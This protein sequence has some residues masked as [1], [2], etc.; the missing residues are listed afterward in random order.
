MADSAISAGKNG[1]E[2]SR[3]GFYDRR[4]T[5]QE[6]ADLVTLNAGEDLTDEVTAARVAVRRVLQHLEEALTPSEYAHMAQVI[7]T[8]TNTIVRL[9]RAQQDLADP[10]AERFN[11]AIGQALDE[12]S[13]E[14]K[15]DL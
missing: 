6:I 2:A 9:L 4:Y 3:S 11:Q 8:G 14:L 5:L 13:G 12:L 7:F 15:F 10:R 1:P